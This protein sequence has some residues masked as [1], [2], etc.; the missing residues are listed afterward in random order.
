MDEW[1]SKH[2]SLANAL[3]DRP[4]D[5]A[6]LLRRLA[7]AID[8]KALAPNEILDVTISSEV[9]D[10]GPWWSATLYWSPAGRVTV[11]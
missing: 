7:D 10:D 8:E 3:D 4:G 11:A 1:N 5:L 9:T 6:H 2:F